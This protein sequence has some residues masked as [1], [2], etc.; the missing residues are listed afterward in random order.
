MHKFKGYD[1]DF[2]P[3]EDTIKCYKCGKPLS[4]PYYI[5]LG[6]NYCERCVPDKEASTE[7]V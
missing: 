1:P 6:K 4:L 7:A 5:Y 2:N 3:F